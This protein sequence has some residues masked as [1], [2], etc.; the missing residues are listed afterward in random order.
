MSSSRLAA[1]LTR[2]DA[3]LARAESAI[4]HL[5]KRGEKDQA[6]REEVRAALAELDQLIT[7]REESE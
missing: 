7:A 5:E 1:A 2:A 6:L 3:A 4:A